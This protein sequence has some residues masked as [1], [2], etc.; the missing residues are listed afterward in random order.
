MISDVCGSKYSRIYSGKSGGAMW[1]MAPPLYIE[2]GS[3]GPTGYPVSPGLYCDINDCGITT[4]SIHFQR[5][6]NVTLLSQFFTEKN[7][8]AFIYIS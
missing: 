7:D 5:V 1:Y 4:F 6:I 3:G 2:E 8:G